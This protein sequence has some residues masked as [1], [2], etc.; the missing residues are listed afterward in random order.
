MTRA[1]GGRIFV[2]ISILIVFISVLVPAV[3]A[4]PTCAKPDHPGGDWPMMGHDYHHTRHQPAEKEIGPLE[5]ATLAPAWTVSANDASGA[6][7]NEITGYPIVADG[8]VYAASS[9]GNQQPGYV[10]AI[11]ADTGE[12]VW[13]TKLDHGVYS[14]VA[15]ADGKVYAFA[16]RVVSSRFEKT[17]GGPSCDQKVCGPYLVALDQDSGSVLWETTVDFQVGSDAVSSPIIWNGLVW[18]GISAT[19]AEGEE[20]ERFDFRGA[21]VLVDADTGELLKWT[22]TIPDKAFKNGKGDAGGA[23]WSTI[24][25]DERTRYG[26]AG[27]GNPFNYENEH[28]RTNAILKID[29]D[30]GRPTFGEV[31]DSY[32]GDVEEYFPQVGENFSCDENDPIGF[33]L[34]GLECGRLDVDFGAS[35]QIFKLSNGRV[36]VGEGQKSGV[37]HVVNPENMKPIW[38]QVIGVPSAVGGIV[39]TPAFDGESLYIPHTLVG[40]LTSLERD[41]GA[42]RWIAPIGDGIHW[43]NPVTSANGVIYTPDLK[44]F[45]DAYDAATGAPLLHR[46]MISEDT[47]SDP[48]FSWGGVSVAR[49]TVYAT[50]GIGLSSVG[51]EFPKMP[52]GFVI[53]FR[54]A[55]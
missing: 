36:V 21:S 16:S 24:A 32:K 30:R 13:K 1:R 47:G 50:T 2:A 7:N 28:K 25:I 5:A 44:G 43:G 11:N 54:P 34:A 33:F 45:L 31:L 9:T 40:Y 49:N 26:Y 23:L 51:S 35:P 22:P 10:F 3:H 8:C 55:G 37:Y 19:A 27:T 20:S 12:L 41:S 15:V 42:H 46:P 48:T 4:K 38:T 52:D 29:L 17:K 18:I 39:G 53:A 14:S 6:E